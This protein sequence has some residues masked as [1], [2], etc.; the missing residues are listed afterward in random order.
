MPSVYI[1]HTIVRKEDV[2]YERE[3]GDWMET[4]VFQEPH[5]CLPVSVSR[6]T[7]MRRTISQKSASTLR[8]VD[9]ALR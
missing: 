7:L 8:R 3:R 6:F 9:D 1:H 5:E 4:S 2:C